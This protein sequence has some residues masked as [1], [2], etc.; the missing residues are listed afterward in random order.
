MT[1]DH[2][3]TA[4]FAGVIGLGVTVPLAD[5]RTRHPPAALVRSNVAGKDV[6]A[7][8]G[9]PMSM[10]ALLAVA[11]LAI[12]GIGGW[13][14]ARLGPLGLAI[15][16]VVVIM[17]LAGTWDDLRGEEKT[18]GFRGHLRALGRGRITGGAVKVAAGGLAGLA[19]GALV[20][21]GRGM[22]EVA[23]LVALT[24]NLVNLLDRAPGRA[25]KVSVAIAAP[26][27]VFG[28]PIWAMASSGLLGGL[29]GCLPKDL[30]GRAMLGDAGA[31]P[32][33]AVL[34]LGLGVSL[35]G[36]SR[37]VAVVLLAAVNL[38]SERWSFSEIIERNGALRALDRWGTGGK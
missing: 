5:F 30:K 6:P 33:G 38:A 32:L 8:L 19:A 2:V 1:L 15:P 27:F 31:N 9:G 37:L 34:G 12:V 29:L 24:A 13:R 4:V 18:R 23:L 26:L 10:G 11:C 16:V 21:D 25:G 17:A 3:V 22:V 7:V 35:P 14:P 36:L 20:S 28:S